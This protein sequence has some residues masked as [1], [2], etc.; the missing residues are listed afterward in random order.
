MYVFGA[1]EDD[2]KWGI[3]SEKSFTFPLCNSVVS[4][5]Q[6]SPPVTIFQKGADNVGVP[7]AIIK[8]CSHIKFKINQAH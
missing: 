5:A 3:F 4:G 7:N 6:P 1:D 8:K 2:Q